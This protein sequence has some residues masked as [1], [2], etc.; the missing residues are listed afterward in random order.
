MND[1]IILTLVEV[2]LFILYFISLMYLCFF[3]FV[4]FLLF[5]LNVLGAIIQN[6]NAFSFL[7]FIIYVKANEKI[8]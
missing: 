3:L 1:S 7:S 2:K 5:N 8:I 4:S 6:E